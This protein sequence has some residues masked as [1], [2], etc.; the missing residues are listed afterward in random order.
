MYDRDLA[1]EIL[2]Q[3]QQAGKTILK[4]FEPVKSV[5]DFTDSFQ[6]QTGLMYHTSKQTTRMES[7][8]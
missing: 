6:H 7:W 1:L 3:L 5:R 4:R 2:Q 8:N